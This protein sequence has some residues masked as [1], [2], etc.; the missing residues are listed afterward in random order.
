M[1][2]WKT[3]DTAG[4]LG[5][6]PTTVKRWV[7]H[8]SHYFQKDRLGHYIFSGQDVRRLQYV[9][10]RME[11]GDSLEQITLPPLVEPGDNM[12]RLPATMITNADAVEDGTITAD[13]WTAADAGASAMEKSSAMTA[14]AA[15]TSGGAGSAT[16]TANGSLDAIRLSCDTAELMSRIRHVEHTLSQ[17]ADEIVNLQVLQHRMELDELRQMVEQ[18][19]RSVEAAGTPNATPPVPSESAAPSEEPAASSL[20]LQIRHKKRGLLRSFFQFL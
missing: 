9:K 11:Q 1:D 14:A 16:T 2:V 20:K 7:L 6:S 4:A 17:K 5:V 19:I 13:I 18:L 15:S 12:M 10:E 3:K 8:F